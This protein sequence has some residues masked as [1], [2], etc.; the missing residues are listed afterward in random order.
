MAMS[1]ETS[2]PVSRSWPTVPPGGRPSLREL[3]AQVVNA[4]VA[5][6]GLARV[7]ELTAAAA[8]GPVLIVAPQLGG[9]WVGPREHSAHDG[10]AALELALIDHLNDPSGAP[11]SELAWEVPIAGNG[12]K[13][14]VA[15]LR[16]GRQ[17]VHPGAIEYLHVASLAAVTEGAL[18][19]ARYTGEHG[20]WG[21][22]LKD[23]RN[24]DDL[25]RDEIV[26]R[27]ALLG[28]TL[29]AGAVAICAAVTG[30]RCKHVL[31]MIASEC[32]NALAAYDG[33]PEP[34][35]QARRLYALVPAAGHGREDP[36]GLAERTLAVARRLGV[37]IG[38]HG[39]VGLSSYCAD[40]A[41]LPYAVQEAGLM[42]EVLLQ[43][44]AP[45]ASAIGNNGTYRL[46]FGLLSS[47]PEELRLLYRD[48]IAPL[49]AYDE[50]YRTELVTTLESYLAENCNM[51]ATA[52]TMFAHR[53]TIA[54]RL[55]RIRE[56]T[57]LDPSLSEGRERLGLGLKAYH[58]VR[59][60]L[61][62]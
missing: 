21:S 31:A 16:T 5:G 41:A 35:E 36:T 1:A 46:L 48:T 59:L 30:E 6:E 40:P 56:L 25:D 7:A 55:E 12:I 23:L 47:R 14:V 33:A 38:R 15:L 18:A 62:H 60:Q 24:R 34:G 50:Q 2:L 4:V 8:G 44:G 61:P 17:T 39:T 54:Y 53:H 51:N 19:E 26:R 9:P 58:L 42:L 11:P 10:L 22:L 52:A 29:S 3:Q 57:G 37:R 43:S 28:C 32:P 20:T 45:L 49:V 27:A 13:G